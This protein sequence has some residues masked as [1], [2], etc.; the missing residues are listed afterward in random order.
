MSVENPL[1]G[2]PRIHG[3]LLKLGFDAFDEPALMELLAMR[4][5]VGDAMMKRT[6]FS[7]A[8]DARQR[9]RAA[10]GGIRSTHGPNAGQLSAAFSHVGLVN[11]A[12][13]L[14]RAEG[15]ARA[16]SGA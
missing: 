15:P 9:C 13:N 8:S 16:R 6:L 14:N 1:W 12:L 11:T 7:S 4:Q 5:H 2:A 3:E 10:R